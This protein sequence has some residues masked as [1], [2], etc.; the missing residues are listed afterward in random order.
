MVHESLKRILIYA[1]VGDI[2]ARAVAEAIRLKG[3][4]PTLWFTA[5]FPAQQRLSIH[6]DAKGKTTFGLSGADLDA[7]IELPVSGSVMPDCRCFD[8]IWHRRGSQPVL[9]EAISK[10]D[11]EVANKEAVGFLRGF[12]MM[13]GHSGFWVNPYTQDYFTCKPTQLRYARM[14]GFSIPPTLFSNDPAH[15]RKFLSQHGE[16]VIY[17]IARPAQWETSDGNYVAT[18]SARLHTSSLPDD[19][20][21]AL[22]PGIFQAEVPKKYELRVVCLG[23]FI[24]GILI[25]SQA[26]ILT[27]TDWRN[28]QALAKMEKYSISDDIVR[29]CRKLMRKLNLVFCCMDLVVTPADE[30]VFLEV[31]P[32]GQFLWMELRTGIPVLDM[33]TE[34]LIHG[35]RD[36][37]WNS[38]HDI[39]RLEQIGNDVY[40]ELMNRDSEKH[41]C[42]PSPITDSKESLGTLPS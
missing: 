1:V 42:G 20:T 30:V 8:T 17:K 37:Q 39:I 6:I 5:D 34:F 19:E 38:E 4:Q 21:L 41:L 24:T 27:A 12:S 29:K 35:A 7:T 33:F 28:C 23:D 22:M 32:Q 36:F 11:R 2:H 26:N 15:I 25:D 10:L 18:Y 31:N 3:H 14:S 13:L 16:S 40:D 9:S